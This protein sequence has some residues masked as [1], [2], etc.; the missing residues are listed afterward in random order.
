M[1]DNEI[2][3]LYMSRDE[4]AITLTADKYGGYCHAV[5]YNILSSKEDA[6][7]CVNDTWMS[8]WKS[9]PPNH[10]KNLATYLGKITRNHALNKFKHNNTQKRGMGQIE[11]ALSELEECVP[12][13]S[14]IE[15]Y[16]NEAELTK[17]IEKFLLTQ[18]KNERNI[19]IGRYWHLYSVREIASCYGMSES[20]VGAILHRTRKKLKLY[21]EKEGI[22]L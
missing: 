22:Y 6:E 2:I 4:K 8:A 19:F 16:F 17:A 3:K 18:K 7:E 5:A 20:K 21:L 10:P 11:L 14:G 9:I 15:E 1:K 12:T 13:S